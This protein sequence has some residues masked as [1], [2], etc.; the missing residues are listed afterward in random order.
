MVRLFCP[1]DSANKD[2]ARQCISLPTYK[3]VNFVHFVVF[4]DEFRERK[5]FFR[6]WTFW[7]PLDLRMCLRVPRPPFLV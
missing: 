2:M 3:F 4:F 5:C 1:D 6:C 7:A